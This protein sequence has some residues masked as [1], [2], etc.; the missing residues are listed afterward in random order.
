MCGGGGVDGEMHGC[1]ARWGRGRGVV[2]MTRGG[3]SLSL[4]FT[5]GLGTPRPVK[6]NILFFIYPD[7]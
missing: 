2:F 1:H 6:R 7:M 4:S 5:F 3:L